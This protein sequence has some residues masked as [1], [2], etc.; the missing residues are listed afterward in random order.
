MGEPDGVNRC[1]KRGC[2]RGGWV[3]K[4]L[5]EAEDGEQRGGGEGADR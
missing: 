4:A 3:E 2:K 5:G 1:K